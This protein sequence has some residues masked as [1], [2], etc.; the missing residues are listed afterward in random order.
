MINVWITVGP[1]VQA[2]FKN[3]QANPDNYTGPMDDRSWEILSTF[4]DNSVVQPMFKVRGSGPN[5]FTLFSLNFAD[6]ETAV[7]DVT[8]LDETWPKPQIVPEGMW[9]YSGLQAGTYYVEDE[10]G[11][12][13]LEGTPTF[14]VNPNLYQSMPDT[15]VY[16]EDGNVVQTIPATSNADLRDVNLIQGQ[17]PRMFDVQA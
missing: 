16:D 9:Y 4:V 5:A 14:P 17:A 12:V 2:A 13:T 15:I 7:S 3:R 8:Y 11:N 6:E 10:E 1:T